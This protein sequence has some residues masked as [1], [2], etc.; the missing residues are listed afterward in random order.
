MLNKI[1]GTVQ[2]LAG[3]VQ[4]ALG[5][6]TGD[7]RT[8]LEGKARQLGGK[9]QSGYGEVLSQVRHRVS[10]NPIGAL[11]VVGA[12]AFAFAALKSKR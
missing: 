8:Q 11:A 4:D 5:S 6:A 9:A 1:E 2:N 10:K 12:A 7:K 3:R